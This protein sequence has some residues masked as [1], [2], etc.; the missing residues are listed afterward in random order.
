MIIATTKEWIWCLVS[1]NHA[2]NTWLRID[3]HDE[4]RALAVSA[5][6]VLGLVIA[7]FFM[8]RLD[9]HRYQEREYILSHPLQVQLTK[10][11]RF[12]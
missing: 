8:I 12:V 9:I 10:G 11:Q 2:K 5:A 3:D 1:P 4:N 6:F 7:L